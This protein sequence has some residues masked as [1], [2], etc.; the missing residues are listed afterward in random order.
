[1]FSVAKVV[2]CNE[3][4]VRA[5]MGLGEIK[6][7]CARESIRF[8]PRGE[9]IPCVYWPL[10]GKVPPHLDDIPRFGEDIINHESFQLA[11]DAPPV[12]SA[13]PCQ[14]GCASR[15]ALNGELNAHDEYCPWVR[16]ETMVL[17]WVPAPHQELMRSRNVCTTIVL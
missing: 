3:P 4:V 6:S 5:A 13:C 2:S 10:D 12:A 17:E 9:I 8:N 16:G 11:R 7:P 1:L 14:G 15:R